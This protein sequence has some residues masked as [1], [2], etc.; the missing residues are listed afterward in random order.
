MSNLRSYTEYMATSENTLP[1]PPAPLSPDATVAIPEHIV[2]RAFAAETVVLNLQTGRYHGLNPTGGR[3]IAALEGGVTLRDAAA[4]LAADYDK[5]AD[6][7][8]Q[9]LCEFCGELLARGLVE[10]LDAGS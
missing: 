3:M 8:E 4:Q 6:V 9:D 10:L 1:V 5:P 2:Y 7:I